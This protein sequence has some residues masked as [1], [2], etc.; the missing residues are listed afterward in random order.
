[1]PSLS[2]ASQSRML[3]TEDAGVFTA[4]FLFTAC[5]MPGARARIALRVLMKDDEPW[6][7]PR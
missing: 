6:R 7:Q 2:P 1:M 5:R 3:I 4:S